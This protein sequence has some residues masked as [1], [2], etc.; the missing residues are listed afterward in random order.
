MHLKMMSGKWRPFCLGV[1]VLR[2]QQNFLKFLYLW[3]IL[4]EVSHGTSYAN[5]NLSVE[6]FTKHIFLEL[7]ASDSNNKVFSL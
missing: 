2:E 3:K 5:E 4:S 7:C 6:A 1:N